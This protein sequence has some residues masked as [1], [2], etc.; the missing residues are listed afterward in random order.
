LRFYWGGGGGV[1]FLRK[2][3]NNITKSYV[4]FI[5]VYTCDKSINEFLLIF[6]FG[7]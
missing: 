7:H 4:K 1:R 5:F 2:F 3:L 6:M